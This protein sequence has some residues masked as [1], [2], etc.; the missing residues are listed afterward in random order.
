MKNRFARLLLL[1]LTG[2]FL[3][4]VHGLFTLRLEDG[5]MFP[6]YSSLRTDPMGAKGFYEAL[7]ALPGVTAERHYLGLNQLRAQ[8]NMTLFYLGLSSNFLSQPVEPVLSQM[9]NLALQGSRIVLSFRPALHSTPTGDG[10]STCMNRQPETIDDYELDVRERNESDRRIKEQK[11]D[12]QDPAGEKWGVKA[13]VSPRSGDRDDLRSAVRLQNG[14]DD[15]PQSIPNHTRLVFETSDPAWQTLYTVDRNPVIVERSLGAGSVVL[16]ADG[17]LFSNEAM[18]DAR[19]PSLL[20][21]LIGT[22]T[23]IVFDEFHFGIQE[24]PGIMDL[25]RKHGLMGFLAALLVLAGLFAWMNAIPFV[26]MAYDQGEEGAVVSHDKDQLSGLIHLLRRNIPSRE[27][28]KVCFDEWSKSVGKR[29]RMLPEDRERV[30]R[31]IEREQG[32]S[33]SPRDLVTAYN[34]IS[35]ILSEKSSP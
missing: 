21:R 34:R 12:A 23:R 9:E 5:E 6:V 11:D 30:L 1:I 25:L 18:R 4:G 27:I 33:R 31:I 32:P 8:P 22:G 26:P 17:Y 14:I 28:L 3:Y 7:R 10:R 20:C 16:V 19:S 35:R 24:H 13:L 29:N 2:S 15:L